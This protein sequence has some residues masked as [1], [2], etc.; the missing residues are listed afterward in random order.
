MINLAWICSPATGMAVNLTE[1]IELGHY[2]HDAP[3]DG[4]GT[5][6]VWIMFVDNRDPL[7]FFNVPGSVDYVTDVNSDGTK[8]THFLTMHCS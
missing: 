2:S 6:S 3:G 7:G 8:V 5:L 1:D 4:A